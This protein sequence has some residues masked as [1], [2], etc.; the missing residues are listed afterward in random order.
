MLDRAALYAQLPG[1]RRAQACARYGVSLTALRARLKR[2]GPYFTRA[3]LVLAGITRSGADTEG[4]LGA[5]DR[6]A[7]YVDW[8]NHDGCSADEVR[9][10]LDQLVADGIIAI[11]GQRFR[12]L[13]DW[14]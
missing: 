5:L 8:L 10:I 6:L 11:D 14:P 7:G 12:L 9:E 4:E 3:D 2:G 1:V 13:V